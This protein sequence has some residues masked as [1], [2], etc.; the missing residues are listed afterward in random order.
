MKDDI[1]ELSKN[2]NLLSFKLSI[3]QKKIP[4]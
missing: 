1:L 4:K 3:I 2:T